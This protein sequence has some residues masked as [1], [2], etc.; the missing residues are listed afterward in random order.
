MTGREYEEK[1]ILTALWAGL[2][3]VSLCSCRGAEDAGERGILV[4]EAE[5]VET[6]E[7]PQDEE[8]LQTPE[9][10]AEEEMEQL[11]IEQRRWIADKE[12]QME[13]A[14]AGVSDSA[15]AEVQSNIVGARLTLDRIEE[16]AV[17]LESA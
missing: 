6:E 15:E 9:T 16:L 14:A 17:R 12:R 5:R 7:T 11:M 13:E 8:D 10:P 3:C 1:T 4:S 2:V